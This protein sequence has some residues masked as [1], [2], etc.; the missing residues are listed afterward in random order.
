[1]N[2]RPETHKSRSSAIPANTPEYFVVE[3]YIRVASGLLR[4]LPPPFMEKIEDQGLLGM[5]PMPCFWFL[6]EYRK[7][8]EGIFETGSDH[9]QRWEQILGIV[10]RWP[11]K[12]RKPTLSILFGCDSHLREATNCC[13]IQIRLFLDLI[14]REQRRIDTL[15]AA[16]QQPSLF[17][18]SLTESLLRFCDSVQKYLNQALPVV[19][20]A[21]ETLEP[22]KAFFLNPRSRTRP[23]AKRDL[24]EQI[25]KLRHCDKKEASTLVANLLNLADPQRRVSSEAIRQ[26]SYRRYR[27]E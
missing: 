21:R 6:P 8:T 24:L 25:R 7:A 4:E 19:K 27:P 23:E 26:L 1:M 11:A 18:F 17:P 22:A 14:E 9:L 2:R 5:A 10:A 13:D 3:A 16:V 20:K 12:I 15:R